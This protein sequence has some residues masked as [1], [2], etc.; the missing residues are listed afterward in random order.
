MCITN[1]EC[2]KCE[3]CG[4]RKYQFWVD[5]EM[6]PRGCPWGHDRMDRCPDK[7]DQVKRFYALQTEAPECVTQSMRDQIAFMQAAG[8][9]LSAPLQGAIT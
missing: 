1:R 4:L 2:Q 9:D 7:L 6:H 3:T 5:S 8:V